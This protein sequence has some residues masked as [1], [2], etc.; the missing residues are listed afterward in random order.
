MP[1]LPYFKKLGNSNVKIYVLEVVRLQFTIQNAYVPELFQRK[2]K[3][4]PETSA[5]S[6]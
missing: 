3:A 2:T 6:L 5:A 4:N 1:A